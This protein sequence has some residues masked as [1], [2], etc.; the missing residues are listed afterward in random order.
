MTQARGGTIRVELSDAPAGVVLSVTDQGE[1]IAAEAARRI[2]TPFFTTKEV[3]ECTGLG[4]AVFKNIVEE[5]G[6][7]IEFKNMAP[8]WGARF[9]VF[10]PRRCNHALK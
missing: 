4:L 7:S 10:F 6:G 3:G 1:G 5:C 9:K 8:P 2:F